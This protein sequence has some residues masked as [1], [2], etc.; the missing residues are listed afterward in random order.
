MPNPYN[1][2]FLEETQ[3]YYFITKNNIEYKIVF[4]IDHTF[5]SISNIKIDNVFQLVIEKMTDIIEQFDSQ[6]SETIK[7]IVISFFKNELNSMIYVCDNEDSKGHVRFNVFER[8][9]QSSSL[10]ETITKIDNVISFD[11]NGNETVIYTSLL[12]HN[13]NINKDTIVEIYNTM[14]EILNEK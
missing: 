13:E 3:S 2:Y 4:I 8:W 10:L 11:S 1:Y 12:Y 9:Y 5:S 7:D 14:Q 6:V